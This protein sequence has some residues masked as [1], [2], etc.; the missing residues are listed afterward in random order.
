MSFFDLF[1]AR[2]IPN[3]PMK[4]I[5]SINKRISQSCNRDS[6]NQRK[7][8]RPRWTTARA[9][10]GSCPVDELAHETAAPIDDKIYQ[11]T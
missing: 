7:Q 10:H 1:V 6:A 2:T 3:I 9:S 11:S 4:W 5:Y 8:M